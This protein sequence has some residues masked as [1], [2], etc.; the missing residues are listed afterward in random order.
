[1][2]EVDNPDNTE[3]KT[4]SEIGN[5]KVL[6]EREK[7]IIEMVLQRIF[8]KTA[9][10]EASLKVSM[11]DDFTPKYIKIAI[12]HLAAN[13]INAELAKNKINSEIEEYKN[14][15]LAYVFELF[16]TSIIAH[17]QKIN[18]EINSENITEI[19]EIIQSFKEIL[20]QDLDFTAKI[21]ILE[22]LFSVFSPYIQYIFGDGSY[23]YITKINQTKEEPVLTII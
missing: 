18:S 17:L 12:E 20:I 9:G 6:N 22:Y 7:I 19:K 5:K 10:F 16:E 2:K 15:I 1:M 13:F 4:Q 14:L 11:V 3:I 23:K 21:K 8:N